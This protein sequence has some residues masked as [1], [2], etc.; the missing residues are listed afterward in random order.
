[1]LKA[2]KKKSAA[3]DTQGHVQLRML[4]LFRLIAKLQIGPQSVIYV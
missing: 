4:L 1:M 3:K 2:A